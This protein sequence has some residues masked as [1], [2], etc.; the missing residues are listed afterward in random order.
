MHLNPER[1]NNK[2][3]AEENDSQKE[4]ETYLNANIN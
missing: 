4:V 2:L 1:S 3:K